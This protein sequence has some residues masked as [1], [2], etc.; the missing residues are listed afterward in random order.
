MRP[1]LN[2]HWQGWRVENFSRLCASRSTE[3]HRRETPKR[4]ACIIW[5]CRTYSFKDEKDINKLG[6]AMTVRQRRWPVSGFWH[7]SV[8]NCRTYRCAELEDTYR[9]MV[10]IT[11]RL[12]LR[13]QRHKWRPCKFGLSSLATTEI[14]PKFAPD[15]SNRFSCLHDLD[16]SSYIRS[17]FFL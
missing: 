11:L 12:S 17:S 5:S 2:G 1:W 7:C 8:S 3:W 13:A 16:D 9:R 14:Q 6:L 4:A 15:I 10:V